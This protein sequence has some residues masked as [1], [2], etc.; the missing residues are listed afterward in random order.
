M[1]RFFEWVATSDDMGKKTMAE[2]RDPCKVFLDKGKDN[3]ERYNDVVFI[4]D[5]FQPILNKPPEPWAAEIRVYEQL[6]KKTPAS[7]FCALPGLPR[8]D[9]ERRRATVL[10]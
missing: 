1:T 5:L 9:G 4:K 8:V 3:R 10:A 2:A 7:Q 6:S